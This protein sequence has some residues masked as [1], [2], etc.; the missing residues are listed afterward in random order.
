MHFKTQ[1]EEIKDTCEFYVTQ[2]ISSRM[3]DLS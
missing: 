2:D 3:F 1:F